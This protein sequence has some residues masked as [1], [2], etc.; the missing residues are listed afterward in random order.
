M[1]N[2]AGKGVWGMSTCNPG[3][4]GKVDEYVNKVGPALITP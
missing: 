1:K 4:K 2:K 3:T